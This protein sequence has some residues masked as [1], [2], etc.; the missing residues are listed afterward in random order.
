MT[1][2]KATEEV[3]THEIPLGSGLV[4]ALI[5]SFCA[6]PYKGDD[7]WEI[8]SIG[9]APNSVVATD[10]TSAI[11]VGEDVGGHLA[12]QR[13]EAL[14][15]AERAN[16]YGTA[17]DLDSIDLNVDDANEP[18]PMPDVRR[19]IARGMAGMVPIAKLNPAALAS[20][21][22]VA[23]A[24][25]AEELELFQ[26]KDAGE[27]MIGFRFEFFPSSDHVNLF[28]NWE[29]LI[30]ARGVFK[31]NAPSKRDTDDED[32]GAERVKLEV[33]EAAVEP[34]KRKAP[35]PKASPEPITEQTVRLKIVT[36]KKVDPAT[37]ST[38]GGFEVPPI[39]KLAEY[40][41]EADPGDYGPQ[42][43]D[44]LRAN[45]IVARVVDLHVGPTVTLYELDVP[46]GTSVK[47][48]SALA[49]D[50]QMQLAVESI[51]IQAPIPGKKAIGIELPNKV[52]RTVGL[53]EL[54]ELEEF[55]S[56]PERLVMA[57]GQDVAGQPVY[58]DLA[59][60]PHLLIAGATNSG[61]SIGIASI[62]CSLLQRNTPDDLRLVLIDPKKVELSFF[63]GLPH[64]MCPVITENREAP[65]VLR[66][67]WREMDRRYDVL[68]AAGVR[69]IGS[70]NERDG[71]ARM[72]Y[73]VVV[74]DE[75]AD[76]MMTA[77][78]EVETAI[79]ALAQKARA[80][81]I[82]LVVA[83]QRPSVDVVTGLIKAN[84]PSRIA[85]AVSDLTNSRVILD[86]PGAEKLIG[87]GDMLWL[88]V[89]AGGKPRRVQGAFVS[90]REVEAIC[91]HWRSIAEPD[92][93]WATAQD[94]E[95]GR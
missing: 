51:R 64:L 81:G 53:R 66:A 62:L 33:E 30:T 94:A 72:P 38:R 63:E 28:S 12:T 5:G 57:L 13:K 11:I 18:K 82:H 36:A 22:K 34:V 40:A 19:V 83:T 89:N 65:G 69:N 61:K 78:A 32:E 46:P 10:S 95:V 25:G 54:I 76:L 55:W 73:I 88:P 1:D 79:V 52:R 93:T 21:A 92:Y 17:V 58:A 8:C 71:S 47:K 70:Y 77:G 75:L 45:G 20:I 14:L 16:L 39:D 35:K 85:F 7:R 60:T 74:I 27:N 41:G 90:E 3:A 86:T 4:K 42:I 87:R 80:V 84:I 67:L 15:A 29:G 26:T 37:V 2:T 9:L 24:A 59:S 44:T 6:K 68:Q 23:A 43:L 48:V 56:R 49:D 91:D 50:L 31:V